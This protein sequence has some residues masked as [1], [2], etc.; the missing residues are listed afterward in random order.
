MI[1]FHELK[2]EKSI[3][4]QLFD[5]KI[6]NKSTYFVLKLVEKHDGFIAGGFAH[7]IARETL[8]SAKLFDLDDA[9]V[10]QFNL[11][12]I[13]G[14]YIC[15]GIFLKKPLIYHY[16]YFQ[17][18]LDHILRWNLDELDYTYEKSQRGDIDFW[19][20]T[21]EKY[22]NFRGDLFKLIASSSGMIKFNTTTNGNIDIICINPNSVPKNPVCQYLQAIT[23]SYGTPEE[24]ISTFDIYNAM[25]YVKDNMLY[26]PEHFQK[27]VDKNMIHLNNIQYHSMIQ[28]ISKWVHVQGYLGGLTKSSFDMLNEVVDELMQHVTNG[29]V[30]REN[31]KFNEKPYTPAEFINS[32]L[33]SFMKYFSP[34]NLLKLSMYFT[35]SQSDYNL[36]MKELCR[37]CE[38]LNL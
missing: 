4:D 36:P 21:K 35:S 11:N 18:Y 27:L 2:F 25:C 32:P 16:K 10:E 38:L 6:I 31:M 9:K 33:S 3:I 24:I 30:F 17:R 12:Q 19:F 23:M 34:E 1:K 14:R 20:Q 37:R 28:R 5:C 29:Q 26:I 15:D 13:E 7:N 22:E 8:I